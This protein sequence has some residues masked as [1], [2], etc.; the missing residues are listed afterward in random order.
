MHL[1]SSVK[2]TVKFIRL[3][4]LDF[5]SFNKCLNQ[6]NLWFTNEWG[7]IH[8]KAKTPEQ[9][10]K[11]R[12]DYLA[13]NADRVHLAFYGSV[14]VGAFRVENKEFDEKFIRK[15]WEII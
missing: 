5:I 11:D 2:P 12:R 9:A 1:F 10:L 7:Y 8:D 15:G 3:N 4:E 14:M 13:E 6:V